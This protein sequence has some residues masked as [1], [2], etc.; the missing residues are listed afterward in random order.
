MI[1]LAVTA[2]EEA[3]VGGREALEFLNVPLYHPHLGSPP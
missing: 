3:T 1:E 2:F